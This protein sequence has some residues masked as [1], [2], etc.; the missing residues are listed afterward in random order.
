MS[1]M[2]VDNKFTGDRQYRGNTGVRT[3]ELSHPMHITPRASILCMG[4]KYLRI[5]DAI[6]ALNVLVCYVCS[7]GTTYI[8]S[9]APTYAPRCQPWIY[10]QTTSECP[11]C[12][13]DGQR[14]WLVDHKRG[15]R[16]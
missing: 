14:S 16:N 2:R 12:R 13:L 7:L 3:R 11:H 6:C 5:S 8:S 10:G 4:A 1:L 9:N 15:A